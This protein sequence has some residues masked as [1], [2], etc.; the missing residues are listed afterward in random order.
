MMMLGD[1]EVFEASVD[2]LS[3]SMQQNAWT[4]YHTLRN[5]LLLCFTSEEMK[6]KFDTCIADGDEETARSLAKLFTNFGETYTDYIAKE[7]VNPNVGV[8]LNMIMRLTGFE[9]YFPV[10]QEVSEIPLN[11]WYILQETLYDESVL[12]INTNDEWIK[13]CGQTA[14]AIY[15]ELVLVLIKNA[16]YPDDNIWTT[17]NKGKKELKDSLYFF[18]CS[19]VYLDMQDRFKIWRRDLGDTMI[20]PYYVLRNDMLS[21]LLEYASNILNQWSLL[22]SASQVYIII[23]FLFLY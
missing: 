16:R 20:N 10:D 1:E 19:N 18:W 12:P 6:V 22:L 15:R 8:L 14:I 3:E 17:W 2:V 13:N 23:S 21:I 4:K 7:L 9:G 11:F 5:D